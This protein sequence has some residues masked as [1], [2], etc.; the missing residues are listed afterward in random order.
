MVSSLLGLWFL[1]ASMLVAGSV[2]IGRRE[3]WK[4]FGDAGTAG[5]EPSAVAGQEPFTDEPDAPPPSVR[6]AQSKSKA[7]AEDVA[8]NDSDEIE[9]EATKGREDEGKLR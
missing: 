4:E 8:Y 3:E 2:I 1:G 5:A 6:P 9:L 7:A